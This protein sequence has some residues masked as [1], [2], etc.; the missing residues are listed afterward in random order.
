MT[1]RGNEKVMDWKALGEKYFKRDNLLIL[2]LSGVL[3][4]VIAMPVEKTKREHGMRGQQNKME[5]SSFAMNRLYPFEDTEK[6]EQQ[7]LTDQ[8]K[9]MEEDDVIAYLENQLEHL[10]SQMEGVGKA[11]VMITLAES[12]ELVVEKD[13]NFV[14]GNTNER[15]SN[16]GN[17]I[18]TQVDTTPTTVYRTKGGDSEPYVVKRISPKVEG[19]VIVA[20]G[21]ESGMVSKEITEMVQVLFDLDVH[22]V[23]VV[24]MAK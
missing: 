8:E 19:V 22:K 12:G 1:V 3:L 18:I 9:V 17:R 21:A 16:G 10:L 6:Q 2:I 14:R 13:E 7:V 20:E 11:D 24:K 5:E 4:F 23:K 15:D